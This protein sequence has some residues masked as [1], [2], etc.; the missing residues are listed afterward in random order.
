MLI[1]SL[2]SLQFVLGNLQICVNSLRHIL[3]LIFIDLQENLEELAMLESL[4]NGKPLAMSKAGDVPLVGALAPLPVETSV[5]A[6]P[7][8]VQGSYR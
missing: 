5:N 4:D 3:Q 7:T 2:S 1:S 8:I 6:D